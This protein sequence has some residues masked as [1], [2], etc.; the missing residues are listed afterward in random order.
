MKRPWPLLERV[1]EDV[2][3]ALIVSLSMTYRDKPNTQP[4]VGDVQGKQL[5]MLETMS[6]FS[7][8]RAQ[9][10]SHDT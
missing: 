4:D 8:T 7:R 6:D 5:D 9:C 10:I 2:S 3:T 1:R